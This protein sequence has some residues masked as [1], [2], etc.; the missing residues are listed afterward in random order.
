MELPGLWGRRNQGRAF[1]AAVGPPAGIAIPIAPLHPI[2]DPRRVLWATQPRFRFVPRHGHS[3]Q[4]SLVLVQ[5]CRAVK[6]VQ[7][8]VDTVD[9]KLRAG[10][11]G[12]Q[13]SAL[14]VGVRIWQSVRRAARGLLR[15][16]TSRARLGLL[17]GST[18]KVRPPPRSVRRTRTAIKLAPAATR[19]LARL[20]GRMSL[21]VRND[22]EAVLPKLRRNP[23]GRVRCRPCRIELA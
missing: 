1:A 17:P 22:Q 20:D 16:P 5:I 21:G 3:C 8:P 6:S 19:A 10:Q 2:R 14:M 13:S 15:P 9:R 11:V 4:P 23:G 18:H 7:I 12:E